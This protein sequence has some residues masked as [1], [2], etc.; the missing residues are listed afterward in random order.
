MNADSAVIAH[1]N[2]MGRTKRWSSLYTDKVDTRNVHVVTRKIRTLEMLRA[3]STGKLLD[4]GCGPGVLV[5]EVLNMGFDYLG[6]DLAEEML[7]EGRARWGEN[8]RI[9]FRTGDI[10][11]IPA[12]ADSFQAVICLGVIEYVSDLVAAIRELKRVLKLG[13]VAIISNHNKIHI[14]NLVITALTPL[15]WIVLPVVRRL[16]TARPDNLRRL[17]MQP[18]QL[19][20]L[21]AE[22]GFLLDDFAL[23]HFTPLP[24]PFT[25]LAPRL[26]HAVN[27]CFENCYHRRRMR[28]LA[29]GYIGKYRKHC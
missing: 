29:H 2:E 24:Y 16:R 27:F 28:F 8:Q 21:M 4:I 18:S 22:A 23:Y 14:D 20:T 12:E 10:E 7:S 26:T 5:E 25:V 19:D 11:H 13:G 3:V 17:L 15:R 9:A 6:M 1:W